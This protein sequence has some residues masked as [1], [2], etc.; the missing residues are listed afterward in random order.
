M[1]QFRII[2]TLWWSLMIWFLCF[3]TFR[4]FAVGLPMNWVKMTLN[5]GKY[6][7]RYLLNMDNQSVSLHISIFHMGISAAVWSEWCW[8]NTVEFQLAI[9]ST[10]KHEEV[11]DFIEKSLL[12]APFRMSLFECFLLQI[13]SHL[14]NLANVYYAKLSHMS[15]CA[16]SKHNRLPLCVG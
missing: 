6:W 2:L 3:Q 10:A 16:V 12:A 7:A 9:Q 1:Y 8:I 14:H 15:C 4:P 13:F 5:A 11:C